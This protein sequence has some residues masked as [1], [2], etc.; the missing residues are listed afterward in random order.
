MATQTLSIT[1][2]AD[3]GSWSDTNTW[4]ATDGYVGLNWYAGFSF[5]A[6]SAIPA[7][8]TVNDCR[9]RAYRTAEDSGTG[10][11]TVAIENADPTGNTAWS[12]GHSPETATMYTGASTAAVN[13][14][15]YQSRYVFGASDD[16]PLNLTS[17][18]QSLV[19]D[20]GGIAVGERINIRVAGG[21]TYFFDLMNVEEA[22]DPS[23]FIDWTPG[24]SGGFLNRNF[25]WDNL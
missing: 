1:S 16:L 6:T 8:S 2:N 15:D 17:Q 7:G 21:P 10:T 24:A 22:N 9:F 3:D 11:A 13:W 25:W 18:L 19:D 23:L 5:V 14:I 4:N 20:H 12:S